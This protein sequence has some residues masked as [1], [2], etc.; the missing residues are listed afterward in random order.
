MKK[1]LIALVTIALIGIIA[2]VVINKKGGSAEQVAINDL[3]AI[4]SNSRAEA[5]GRLAGKPAVVFVVGTFCPHCQSA[6]PK[7]KTDIWDVYKDRVNI[8]A[9]V[10]DGESGKRFD[11]AGIPQGYDAQ[12][13]FENLT[14]ESCDYVPSWVLLDAEGNTVDSSCGAKKGIDVIKSGVDSLLSSEELPLE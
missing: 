14:G 6:M 13:N 8:F 2:Q 10:I 9:H 7:Y 3:G 4:T 12:L 11:V 1:I 5:V